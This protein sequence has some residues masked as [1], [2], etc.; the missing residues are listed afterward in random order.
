[1]RFNHRCCSVSEAERK[2]ARMSLRERLKHMKTF[3]QGQGNRCFKK[4]DFKV[5]LMWYEKSLMYY[6]YC[7]PSNDWEIEAIDEERKLCLVNSAAC[8]LELK[9]YRQCIECCTEALEVA[10]EYQSLVQKS[11]SLSVLVQF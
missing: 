9:E 8:H 6:E 3:R 10:Q 4:Q 5:A 11:K 1:M 7:F 2:V